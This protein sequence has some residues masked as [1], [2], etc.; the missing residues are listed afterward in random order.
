M[1]A[2]SIPLPDTLKFFVD[3]EVKQCGIPGRMPLYAAAIM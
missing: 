3:E 1:S 2:M